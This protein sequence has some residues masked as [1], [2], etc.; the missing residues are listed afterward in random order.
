MSAA[1]PAGLTGRQLVAARQSN[2]QIAGVLSLSVKTVDHHVG[3][4]LAKLAV[5]SGLPAQRWRPERPELGQGSRSARARSHARDLRV[6]EDNPP[7][8]GADGLGTGGAA[9]Q[10]RGSKWFLATREEAPPTRWSM[11][12]VT[13]QCRSQTLPPTLY[14]GQQLLYFSS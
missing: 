4:G 6:A 9:S 10:C 7:N 5:G 11:V 2:A 3:A 1:K 8:A 13:G 14:S 12:A